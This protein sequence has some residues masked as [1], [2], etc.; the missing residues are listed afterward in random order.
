MQT[1]PEIGDRLEQIRKR[2]DMSQAD[3]AAS[4]GISRTTLHNYARGER[5]LTEPVL[6]KLLEIYNADPLWILAGDQGI[7]NRQ[8]TTL[9]A[10]GEILERVEERLAERNQRLGTRKRWM[11]VCRLYAHQI[12][13]EHRSGTRP[14]L[15]TLGLDNLLDMAQ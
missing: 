11:I 9:D 14:T 4:L 3:F 15:E 8:N 6:A 7:Q 10:L 12:S 2:A 1:D 5:V 13:E